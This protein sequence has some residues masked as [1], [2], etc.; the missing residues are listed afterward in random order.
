MQRESCRSQGLISKDKL[1][2]LNYPTY[3]PS[4]EELRE[5]IHENGCFEI[6]RL[7]EQPRRPIPLKKTA[8]IRAGME[9]L[10]TKHF[11]TD[12]MEPLFVRY[13]KKIEA[14]PRPF[15][16]TADDGVAGGLF[17]LLKRKH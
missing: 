13:S 12:I 5:L 11:G 8:E 1:D 9:S 15:L 7:E 10:L 2:S 17:V 14:R 3:S 4:V 16:T 6:A